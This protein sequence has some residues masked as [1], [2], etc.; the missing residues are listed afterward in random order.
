MLAREEVHG[1]EGE[2]IHTLEMVSRHGL[3]DTADYPLF[4]LIHDIVKSPQGVHERID[5]YLKQ[6]YS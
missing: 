6:V 3:F 1:V 4:Q 2:G 5:G